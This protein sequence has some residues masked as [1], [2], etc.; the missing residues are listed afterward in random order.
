MLLTVAIINPYTNHIYN[1]LWR[2]M[3]RIGNESEQLERI[4]I[5]KVK[6]DGTLS[7]DLS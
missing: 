2:L 7:L 4:F 5:Y 1:E 6:S 3:E